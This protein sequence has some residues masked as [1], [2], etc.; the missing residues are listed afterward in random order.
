[1][2]DNQ[3]VWERIPPQAK[4]IAMDENEVW[5][6]Y[7]NRP[8]IFLRLNRWVPKGQNFGIIHPRP[9]PVTDWTKSLQQRPEKI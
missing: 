8:A 2:N 3:T 7:I 5:Y 6:W 4:F 9:E 1:M